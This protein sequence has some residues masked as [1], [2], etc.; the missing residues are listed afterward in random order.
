MNGDTKE[1]VAALHELAKE[2]GIL[3]TKH[4]NMEA[5][6]YNELKNDIEKLCKR[7][8][9]CMDKS[10]E[11]RHRD[12]KWMIALMISFIVGTFGWILLFLKMM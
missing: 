8:E 12:F 10:V 7:V 3:Q 6:I 9:K 2:V 11:D 5:Y 4:E 1:I